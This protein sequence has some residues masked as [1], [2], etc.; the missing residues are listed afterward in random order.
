MMNRQD[1]G[2]PWGQDFGQLQQEQVVRHKVKCLGKVEEDGEGR[3]A[4]VVG[5][6]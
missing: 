4:K 1:F 2:Q 3:E 6:F 5:L